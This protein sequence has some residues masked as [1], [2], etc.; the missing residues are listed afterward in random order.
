[1][2]GLGLAAGARVLD[3]CTGTGALAVVAAGAGASEV[4]AVDLS[5]RSA[6]ATRVNTRRHGAEVRVLR[7]DLFA[8][9]DD[10]ERFDL[11][12]SN[13]P[14]VPSRSA[15]LPRHTLGRCW[16]AGLDGRLLVDRIC[17]QAHDRLTPGGS[18][19]LVQSS[20]TDEARTVEHLQD[21]GLA[22]DVVRR[23][24]EPFG[25]VMRSRAE[26]LRARGLIGS[27]QAEEGLVVLRATRPHRPSSAE[28]GADT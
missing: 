2:C 28:A 12:V 3:L 19:L 27:G 20:V 1:M 10:H 15:A 13:P 24:T 6:V 4:A 11:I 17:A 23:R 21:S 14:Y 25:P 5:L 8:P 7:G 16:D 9:L 18:L 26:H 22:V